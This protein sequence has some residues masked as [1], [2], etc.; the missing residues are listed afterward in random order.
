MQQ[1]LSSAY[2]NFMGDSYDARR[3]LLG[4]EVLR[5]SNNK[6]FDEDGVV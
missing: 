6:N 1:G 2:I 3:G 5:A 4:L